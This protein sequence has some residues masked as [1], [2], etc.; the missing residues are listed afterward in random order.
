MSG[1]AIEKIIETICE[2]GILYF[3]IKIIK[4]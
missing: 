3:V 2:I 4:V 1:E